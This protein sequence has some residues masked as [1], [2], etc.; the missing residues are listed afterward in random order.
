MTLSKSSFTSLGQH[1]RSLLHLPLNSPSTSSTSPADDNVKGESRPHYHQYSG[2]EPVISLQGRESPE[3]APGLASPNST[4]IVKKRKSR[5][6]LLSSWIPSLTTSQPADNAPQYRK[7][8]KVVSRKPVV[9]QVSTIDQAFAAAGAARPQE[10]QS[11]ASASQQ[12][13]YSSHPPPPPPPTMPPPPVPASSSSRPSSSRADSSPTSPI[14]SYNHDNSYQS[15]STGSRHQQ[16]PYAAYNPSPVD[17]TTSTHSSTRSK[18]TI[19]TVASKATTSSS[20][21]STKI[22]DG[23]NFNFSNSAHAPT[24][25]FE[26]PGD[27][28]HPQS[29]ADMTTAPR[30][31]TRGDSPADMARRNFSPEVGRYSSRNASPAPRSMT[32]QSRSQ[33]QSGRS[34]PVRPA[35]PPDIQLI[36]TTPSPEATRK[37]EPERMD[38]SS[39][40]QGLAGKK[41]RVA[42][43]GNTGDSNPSLDDPRARSVSAN[44]PANRATEP[45]QP[46]VVSTGT[47]SVSHQAALHVGGPSKPQPGK[48]RKSIFSTAGRSRSN[49]HDAP[50]MPNSAAWIVSDDSAAE[51]NTHILTSGDKVPELWNESSN[52]F[53]H[54]HAREI[55]RK[56]SFKVPTTVLSSSTIFR[57]QMREQL[58][59]PDA[60]MDTPREYHVQVPPSV[61]QPGKPDL[62]RLVTIRNLFAFLTGQPLVATKQQPSLFK[63][64]FNV[65]S[66]LSQFEFSSPDGETYGEIPDVSFSWLMTQVPIADVRQSREKTIEALVL[67]ERM[68]SKELYREAF[69]HAA[70]KYAAIQSLKSPTFALL[71][72]ATQDK[73]E[74]SHFD[75]VN[76]QDTLN[77][78]LETFDFP[79]LFA[80]I[81]S[82]NSA[83]KDVNFARWKTAFGRMR[84]FVLSYYRSHVGS[85]PPKASSKKNNFSESGLNRQVLKMLY[86]DLCALYD[87]LVDRESL[88]Q[89]RIDGSPLGEPDPYSE[90]EFHVSTHYLRRILD[91]CDTST[92]PVL[93]PIP[94]DLPQ[95][96]SMSS[97][98]ENYH[99]MTAKD[100]LAFDRKL[101]HH[102]LLLVLSKAYNIDTYKLKLPFL[103][104]F[105]E[106]EAKEARGLSGGKPMVE[107]VDQRI[108]YWIFMYSVIQ[109]LPMLV[110]DAPDVKFTENVEYFLC[111]P[112]MGSLPWIDDGG[113]KMWFEIAGGGVVELPPEA[114][115][116][117]VQ[118]TYH[119]SHCWLS[120]KIWEEAL[121]YGL[122]SAFPPPPADDQAPS[123]LDPPN[124]VFADGSQASDAGGPP[125]SSHSAGASPALPPNTTGT[126]P[127]GSPQYALRPRNLSPGARSRLL[128]P[129]GPGGHVYRSSIA[130]GIEPLALPEN[131]FGGR[132]ADGGLPRSAS[133]GN[134]R[135]LNME[136]DAPK[137]EN[138]SGNAKS[139]YS[140]SA[141]GEATDQTFD[142]ILSKVDKRQRRARKWGLF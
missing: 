41:L 111:Q 24:L 60:P 47:R 22:N 67:G 89:T 15:G 48:V 139:E 101:Q 45:Q 44:P 3:A 87:L 94:F 104:E 97:V 62:E 29:R 12:Q 13:V 98:Y 54:I 70:G 78:K 49:S 120:A 32:P 113:R 19:R 135:Q 118:A 52:V 55:S 79:A 50:R 102:E 8:G 105:K 59:P 134:L 112:P 26:L 126:S 61:S 16:N 28:K 116:Y 140:D 80:G 30:P 21:S 66:L 115:K 141:N 23:F 95:L 93:P 63:V 65:S 17:N 7:Q 20:Q 124:P 125:G 53:V 90:D 136:N 81:A 129:G 10:P 108:G 1:G 91:E 31:P 114:V 33:P 121:T 11:S 64:V 43:A 71:S 56:A 25:D 131:H 82:S 106:F 68:R 76:R 72:P 75:L 84:S 69:A 138:Q 27:S 6:G 137:S 85:W 107:I 122:D 36:Q 58:P 34:T 42:A 51:Y 103:T 142:N 100:Q 128:A 119:R 4:P 35:P 9:Q 123:P 74:R 73:L 39:S 37:G 110:I 57:R 77:N 2:S 86:S 96:P 130:L 40:L 46:R 109:A 5:L 117:S 99:T 127:S 83:A 133:H 132:G 88:S 92:P 38:R 14:E 18:E